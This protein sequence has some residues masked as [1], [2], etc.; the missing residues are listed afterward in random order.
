MAKLIPKDADEKICPGLSSKE[1]KC[2]C[3]NDFCTA[4]IISEDLIK[5][6]RKFRKTIGV[7]LKINSG[8]RCAAHN[9]TVGGVKLS[10]HVSGEAI[11]ISLKSLSHLEHE[12]IEWAARVSGF[13]FIKFYK[14]FVHLDVR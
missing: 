6:Y 14:A 4:T 5:A 8:Y 12:E 13:S 9:K 10:R 3:K 1:F 2:R 7:P 11:D